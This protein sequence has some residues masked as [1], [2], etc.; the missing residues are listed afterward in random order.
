MAD[1]VMLLDE[2]DKLGRDAVGRCEVRGVQGGC[3]AQIEVQGTG[4]CEGGR[5]SGWL[6]VNGNPETVGGQG[7]KWMD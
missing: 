3:E 2:V 6:G 5:G 7:D 4:G 1:P